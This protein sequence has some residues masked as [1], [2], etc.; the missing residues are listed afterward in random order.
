MKKILIA[1]LAVAVLFG[2]AACEEQG[3][4]VPT[5]LTISTTKASYLE[6]QA[7][8]LS[9]VSGRLEYSDGTFRTLAGN[10]LS[11]V[12]LANGVITASY[13]GAD[14][15]ASVPVTV[16]G[17]ADVTA[18]AVSDLP[19]SAKVGKESFEVP[20]VATLPDGTTAN[21]KASIAVT[22]IAG[23]VGDS[24][25]VTVSTVSIVGDED[26]TDFK[27]KTTGIAD[28]WKVTIV[29]STEFDPEKVASIA[30]VSKNTSTTTG[31]V[32]Y[33]DDVLAISVVATDEEG[34]TKTLTSSEYGVMNG[35]TLEATYTVKGTA[36][37]EGIV[38]YL[39]SDPSIVSAAYNTPV[40]TAWIESVTF[41]KKADAAELAATG[42]TLTV[43]QLATYYDIKT[44]GHGE[45]AQITFSPSEDNC[46]LTNATWEENESTTATTVF[47]PAVSVK[48]GKGEGSWT[49]AAIGQ[50]VVA[51]ASV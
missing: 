15:T 22:A 36:G 6:G 39:A 12:V 19:T 11:N 16:Y 44:T 30:I 14:L 13:G 33:I 29:N 46:I 3:Y 7:V 23:S 35:K 51:K 38:V 9:T 41:T 34:A 25:A 10:E 31:S 42:G 28:D 40:G 49:S 17:Y 1:V 2:F 27:A 37:T 47:T 8:D 26:T 18:L 24:V 5:G 45:T 20:A 50:L 43:Q 48:V 4:K 32:N 21:V